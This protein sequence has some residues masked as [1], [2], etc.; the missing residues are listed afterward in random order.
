MV[1]FGPKLERK[2]ATLFRAVDIGADLFAMAAAVSRADAI[3]RS[4]AAEG[5]R[6][7]E[8]ADLFCRSAERRIRQRFAALS[9]NDD[10][11]KAAVSRR[12]L[13]GEEEWLESG[14]V[15]VSWQPAPEPERDRAVAG[16]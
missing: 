5:G 3:R 13:A 9:D 15:P 11:L 14:L 10:A 6:A 2:Q 7:V 16:R 4:G 8:L 1:R 12:V